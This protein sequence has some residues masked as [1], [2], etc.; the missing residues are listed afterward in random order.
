VILVT[1]G[2]GFVGPKIVGALRAKD[3]PVRLLVRK[4]EGA[5]ELELRGCELVRG[6]VTDAESVRRAVEGC[7]TVIHLVAILAGAPEDFQRVMIDGLHHVVAA[8]RAADT[9]RLV[10]MSA[11]GTGEETKDLVPYFHAKYEMEAAVRASGI[12]HTIFRPSFVFGGDGGVLPTLLR[13][14]RFSPVIPVMGDGRQRSQPIWVD[15]VA[16]FFAASLDLEQARNRT[17]E[18]GGPDAVTWNELYGRIR[19]VLGKR[20]ATVHMPMGLMRR[21]AALLERLPRPPLTR[22]QLTML[23]GPD[24]VA[25]MRPALEAFQLPLVGLDEQIRRAAA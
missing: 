9:Q 17:W 20:R 19:G 10:L 16:A 3:L 8:A 5:R 14:V 6:D 25:D 13:L 21:Q 22:D 2:T 11:L 18:L 15:D 7:D 24:N 4:P 1:G 23:E 12:D